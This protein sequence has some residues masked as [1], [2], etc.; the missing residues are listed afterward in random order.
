[1]LWSL[2]HHT[3]YLGEQ[4]QVET[5][6]TSEHL[7]VHGARLKFFRNKMYETTTDPLEHIDFQMNKLCRVR[8]ITVI[9]LEK[10]S[11]KLGVWRKG[12]ED[13]KSS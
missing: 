11:L 1:M 13:E 3:C 9:Q 12:L 10:G 8:E 7:E 4:L 5:L 2:P 6:R